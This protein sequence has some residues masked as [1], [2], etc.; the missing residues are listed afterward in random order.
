MKVNLKP[1]QNSASPQ[2]LSLTKGDNL[3]LLTVNGSLLP[4]RFKNLDM[5]QSSCQGFQNLLY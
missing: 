5:P 2:N 4:E 1:A 3:D